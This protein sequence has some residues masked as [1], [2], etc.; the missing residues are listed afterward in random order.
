MSRLLITVLAL[1]LVS[2]T[3][4]AEDQNDVARLKQ[5]GHCPGCD[6]SGAYLRVARIANADLSG[7]DLSGADLISADMSGANL[8]RA[9]LSGAN[10]VRASLVG[11]RLDG[12]RFTDTILMRAIMDNTNLVTAE[13]FSAAQL[14]VACGNANTQLPDGFQISRCAVSELESL[15]GTK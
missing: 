7:A 1:F 6:L 5:T 8:T 9:N 4:H 2:A 12:A 15:V 14:G 3:A 11:A 10:L 13:G